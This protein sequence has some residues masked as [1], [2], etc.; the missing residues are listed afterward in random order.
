MI[1]KFLKKIWI[2]KISDKGNLLTQQDIEML[3]H[4]TNIS[5]INFCT[6][7]KKTLQTDIKK[8]INK[9]LKKNT[10]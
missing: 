7:L 10:L 3:T 2:V 8:N 9:I 1:E 5:T 6:S 4:L